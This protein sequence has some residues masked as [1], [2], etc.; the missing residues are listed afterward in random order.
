MRKISLIL[1]FIT[2]LLQI[3]QC[4]TVDSIKTEQAG[5]LIKIHYKI[6][7]SNENQFFRIT[8]FCS[9]NG[10][11]KSV[12]K[13]LSG[14]WGENVVGGKSEYMVLWDVLKD[15]DE[16]K[17]AEF[18][19]NAEMVKGSSRPVKVDTMPLLPR[20]FHALFVYGGA[21]NGQ[22]FG[23]MIGLMGNWGVS[24]KYLTGKEAGDELP[25]VPQE[26]LFTLSLDL[27]K[28]IVNARKFNM[29]LVMGPSI[30]KFKVSDGTY[31]YSNC[32]GL[33]FGFVMSAKR[34]AFLG[35]CSYNPQTWLKEGQTFIS[36]SDPILGYFGIGYRF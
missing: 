11:L 19:V 27:T 28:R 15:V 9:I 1:I 26:S 22:K 8:V 6:L 12:P 13:S 33:D 3:A 29:H 31:Y 18:F 25:G 36:S 17:S 4:Q 34:L 35:G 32:I 21:N 14:D 20:K 24:G 7:N 10:G 23:G 16:L 30:T 2:G 5:D